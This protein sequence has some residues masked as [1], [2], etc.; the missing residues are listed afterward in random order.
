MQIVQIAHAKGRLFKNADSIVRIEACSNYC[1][2]YCTD[3]AYPITVA[4]VLLW[5]QNNL[6]AANFVRTHRTHL[7]NKNFIKKIEAS[8]ILLHNGEI[9]S[10]SRRK[11][12][13]CKLIA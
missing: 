2:I 7:V 6:P 11:K 8:Y 3:E 9:I 13:N 10:I 4:R 5:F 1:K 12:N